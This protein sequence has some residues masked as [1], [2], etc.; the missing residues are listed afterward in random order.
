ML[1]IIPPKSYILLW[2]I[3]LF[4][5]NQCDYKCKTK[6]L[7]A[8]HRRLVH[9]GKKRI[10]YSRIKAKAAKEAANLVVSDQVQ[11]DQQGLQGVPP[12]LSTVGQSGA[13]VGDINVSNFNSWQPAQ[14]VQN[15][16]LWQHHQPDQVS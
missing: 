15:L 1:D 12:S 14:Q 4:S 3:P 13:R 5:C 2:N 8:N 16:L 9:L 6:T 7:M 10:R 11:G